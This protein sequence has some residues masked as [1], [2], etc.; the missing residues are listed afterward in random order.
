MFF[1]ESR[2]WEE[3]CK[4]DEVAGILSMIN[5]QSCLG[6]TIIVDEYQHHSSHPTTSVYDK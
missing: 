3:E 1:F 5:P 2:S 6:T 4:V